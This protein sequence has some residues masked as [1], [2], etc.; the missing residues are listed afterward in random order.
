MGSENDPTPGRG[1]GRKVPAHPLARRSAQGAGAA[2][3]VKRPL[4]AGEHFFT[5]GATGLRR[6]VERRSGAPLVFLFQLPRWLMPVVLVALMLTGLVVQGWPG[7]VAILP[8]LAFV[9]WLAYM[10]WPS[11]AIR[12][13]LL[14]VVALIF[15]VLFAAERFGLI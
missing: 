13:R 14:R 12:G 9:S 15:L 11:L 8:V 2:R 3:P 6:A 4:P 7:G 5:P 1:P 10:S